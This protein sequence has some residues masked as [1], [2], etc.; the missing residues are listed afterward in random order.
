MT[1]SP[2]WSNPAPDRNHPRAASIP[3]MAAK[4]PRHGLANSSRTRRKNLRKMAIQT[5]ILCDLEPMKHRLL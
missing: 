1:P 2:E 5:Y 3:A 4:F